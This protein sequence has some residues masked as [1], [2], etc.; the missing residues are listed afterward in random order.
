M[1]N[2]VHVYYKSAGHENS[3]DCWCEPT[4]ISLLRDLD[5]YPVLVVEHCDD[6]HKNHIVVVAERERDRNGATTDAWV[7]RVLTMGPP[8]LPPHDPNERKV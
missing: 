5:G 3:V 7:T 4:W 1:R 2:E 8:E 6:T